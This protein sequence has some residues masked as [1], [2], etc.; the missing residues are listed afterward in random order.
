MEKTTITASDDAQTLHDRLANI[1]ASL[2]IRTIP[3]YISGA[4]AP[5]PQPN[6]GIVIARKIKKSDGLIDWN[7]S[8]HEVWNRVR[9]LVPWPGAYSHLAGPQ[10]PITIKIWKAQ[11][12]ENS[13]KPGEIIQADSSG[14]VVGCDVGSLKILELQRENARRL[15]A[16]QFVAGHPLRPGDKFV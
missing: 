3:E 9:G 10:S 7:H 6:E 5:A 4:I 13:G 2:L 12:L 8:A 11:P 1:G 16:A 14:I 15:T